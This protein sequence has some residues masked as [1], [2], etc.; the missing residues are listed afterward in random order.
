[1][2][3]IERAIFNVSKP[4]VFVYRV[5]DQYIVGCNEQQWVRNEPLIDYIEASAYFSIRL[6]NSRDIFNQNKISNPNTLMTDGK[7]IWS[8]DLNYY[9]VNHHFLWP[10]DF[11]EH[12]RNKKLKSL[13]LKAL[14]KLGLKYYPPIYSIMSGYDPESLELI[15]Y[16]IIDL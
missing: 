9:T 5:S 7:W 13:S 2:I 11:I 14:K 10:N 16:K 3:N 8:A 6:D 4:V 12:I 15:D 1:M